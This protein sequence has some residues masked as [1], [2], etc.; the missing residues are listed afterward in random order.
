MYGM[1]GRVGCSPCSPAAS[2]AQS[3]AHLPPCDR[4]RRHAVSS[5]NSA[6]S[7]RSLSLFFSHK[8]SLAHHIWNIV[9]LP[10]TM[11]SRR[12]LCPTH[13]REKEGEAQDALTPTDRPFELRTHGRLEPRTTLPPLRRGVRR[14]GQSVRSYKCTRCD[15][16]LDLTTTKRGWRVRVPPCFLVSLLPSSLCR[17][18]FFFISSHILP[19]H[20]IPTPCPS[21]ADSA[22]SG[23]SIDL[24][25]TTTTP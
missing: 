16:L 1:R 23:L 22:N 21:T 13:E 4:A 17:L 14:V 2:L 8:Q 3:H 9:P 6:L 5:F 18:F 11:I 7:A 20:P 15:G 10:C 12:S 24:A 19:S 25:A